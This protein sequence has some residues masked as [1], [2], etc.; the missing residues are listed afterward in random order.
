MLLPILIL[1]T[2]AA[3]FVKGLAGFGPALVMI[4]V[5]SFFMPLTEVVPLSGAL[6]LLSNIPLALSGRGKL[7]R[8]MFV[9]AALGFGVGVA[10]GGQLLVLLSEALLLHILGVTL[11]GFCAYQL[12]GGR[13]VEVAPPWTRREAALLL[14]VSVFSGLIVGAVGAGALPLIV[15]LGLRY[16]K[17]EFRLLLTYVFLV[18]SASQVIVYGARGLYTPEVL[19]MF[20]WLVGPM[21]AGLWLGSSL[22][23]I[24][25]QRTF[26][27]A[28]GVLLVLPAIRLLLS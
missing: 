5:F 10:F 7:R 16:P 27:R 21:L 3:F 24:V 12:W 17:T 6:L 15:F 9:P 23:G 26:N 2:I 19:T 1:T 13:D 28:V 22:F 20:L 11:I 25:K 14:S 18:G 8:R 4:P